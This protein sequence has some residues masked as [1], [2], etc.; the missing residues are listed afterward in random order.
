[1]K[2]QGGYNLEHKDLVVDLADCL[3]GRVI[4]VGEVF[5]HGGHHRRR[6]ADEN[7]AVRSV[8]VGDVLL[9]VFLGDITN[10]TFPAGR[11]VVENVEDLELEFMDVEKFLEVVLEEN[12]FFVDVGVNEGDGGRVERI[13]E[14]GTDD[15]DHGGDTCATSDE[16]EVTGHF[17]LVT[18]VALG[19]LDADGI[20]DLEFRDVLGDVAHFVS[21]DKEVK[22]TTVIIVVDGR[23]ATGNG[24]AFN[25]SRDRYVLSDRKTK[26]ILYMREFEAV[27]GGIRRDDNFLLQRVL[28]PCVRVQRF[29]TTSV[30]DVGIDASSYDNDGSEDERRGIREGNKVNRTQKRE[31][32]GMKIVRD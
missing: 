29:S 11:G 17:W 20:T 5:L 12:V 28:L 23:I 19:T 30:E 4:E 32:N 14:S 16:T 21:F 3:R 1:M 22:V 9:D 8:G 31:L 27:H 2:H 26:N 10:T 13:S 15:L 18:E 7:F 6:T 24:F 25:L